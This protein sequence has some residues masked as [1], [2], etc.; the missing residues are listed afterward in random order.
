MQVASRT[1][2][3]ISSLKSFFAKNKK[4]IV[5]AL[6]VFAIGVLVG[7]L[8]IVRSVSEGFERVARADMQIGGA[9]VFFI[10]LLA[11]LGAY[12]V[13]LIS[14][15]N[16]KTLPLALVPFFVLGFVLGEYVTALV[17]RYEAFG[18]FNLLLVY[19][20]FFVC[21]LVLFILCACNM[22]A[23]DCACSSMTTLKPSFIATLKLF[24]LN[25]LCSIIFFLIIGSIFGVIIVELY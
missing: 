15:I 6:I 3:I 25:V 21:T 11:L 19:L 23:P 7:I 2:V 4:V 16:S 18:V 5:C 22:A 9:R 13:F 1:R 14:G 20:P 10:S 24:G 17:A 12:I 8:S